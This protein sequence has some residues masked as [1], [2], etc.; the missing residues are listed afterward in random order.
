MWPIDR[1]FFLQSS[2][3]I[4]IKG[5]PPGYRGNTKRRSKNGKRKCRKEFGGKGTEGIG[6]VLRYCGV[7]V[8]RVAVGKQPKLENRAPESTLVII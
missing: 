7:C 4:R 6:V 2:L 3:F 1:I 5:S 8:Y